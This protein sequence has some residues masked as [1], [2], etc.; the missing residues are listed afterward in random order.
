[1]ATSTREQLG[2][3]NQLEQAVQEAVEKALASTAKCR[4][5]IPK[6]LDQIG[7]K[8]VVVP[9]IGGDAAIGYGPDAI[10][11]PVQIYQN[12]ILDDQHAQNEG[13]VIRLVAVAAASLGAVEDQ[14]IIWGGGAEAAP[15]PGAGRVARNRALARS[16]AR[17][18][19]TPPVRIT[20]AGPRPTGDELYEAISNAVAALETAN[21]PG[22]YG[23]LVH[24]N[25]MATLRQP[26]IPG[27]VPLIQ[28]VEG[29]IGTSEI[30]GTSAL[31]REVAE[32]NVGGILF[33]LEPAAM[34]LVHTLLPRVVVLG[35]EGGFTNLRLEEEIVLRVLDTAAIQPITY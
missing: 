21:R 18:M 30:G 26:R 2:W 25:L 35:R 29:L 10:A 4:R 14:E 22:Q 27:G 9:T 23:L 11:T 5:V 16:A 13:D 3:T 34:D 24:N 8:A 19:P 6:G 1:M 7:E 32:G 12:A 33:R 15:L 31:D 17:A 28:E 20:H